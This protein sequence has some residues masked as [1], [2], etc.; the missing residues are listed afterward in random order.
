MLSLRH[1]RVKA[2]KLGKAYPRRDVGHIAL[3][4]GNSDVVLP[5]ARLHLGQ[6]VFALAVKRNEHEI[7]IQFVIVYSIAVQPCDRAAFRSRQ[8][9][10]SMEPPV[11]REENHNILWPSK[12]Q[13]T[14]LSIISSLLTTFFSDQQRRAVADWKNE[15]KKIAHRFFRCTACRL[16]F[17]R[18]LFLALRPR[19]TS[20]EG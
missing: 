2:L 10:Y 5:C 8:I 4:A 12:R 7:M 13:S 14:T 17:Y 9:F 16:H 15:H 11:T 19:V 1:E 18:L 6:S 20:R 3:I